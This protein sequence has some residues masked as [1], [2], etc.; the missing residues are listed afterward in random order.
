MTELP[1]RACPEG[2]VRVTICPTRV[3][4]PTTVNPWFS[5]FVSAFAK[6]RPTTAGIVTRGGVLAADALAVGLAEGVAA[7]DVA[8]ERDADAERELA[9]DAGREPPGDAE[10]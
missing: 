9:G 4:F 5:S 7:L 3:C 1:A 10:R 2:L 6:V 8:G